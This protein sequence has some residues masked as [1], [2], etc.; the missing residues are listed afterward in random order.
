MTT[1]VSAK[2]MRAE[3]VRR[4]LSAHDLTDEAQ[5][6]HALQILLREV[7]EA[8]RAAWG[9]EVVIHRESPI[10]SVE[11]NYDALHY[12]P[13]GASRD[14]RY[15]RYLNGRTILRTQTSV[16]IPGLLRRL[17]QRGEP[18]SDVL[19]V[20]P[21]L[22]YRRDAIDRLHMGEPHQ[23]DLWRIKKGLAL[24]AEHLTEMVDLLASSALPNYD[25]RSVPAEHPYTTNG[26]Q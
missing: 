13:E 18:W 20:C 8:L 5:G 9:C 17:A 1:T 26:L 24:S 16:M 25:V 22:V 3:D 4:S 23:M 2:L 6:P 12:P 19:L 11:E 21:G 15:T 10:V 14:A 7:V